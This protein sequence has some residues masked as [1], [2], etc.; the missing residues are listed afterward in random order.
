[1]GN[2]DVWR[3]GEDLA[4]TY[5]SGIGWEVVERNWRCPAG[6]LDIIAK[7]DGAWVF[8]EVRTRRG[9]AFGTPEESLTSAK[10]HHLAAATVSVTR[11]AF[12]RGLQRNIFNRN[13]CRFIKIIRCKFHRLRLLCLRLSLKQL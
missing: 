8:V 6:E 9:R 10:R 13:H 2:V 12:E 5:L 11:A 7:R 4:A 1:M 3:A